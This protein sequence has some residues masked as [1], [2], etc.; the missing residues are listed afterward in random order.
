MRNRKSTFWISRRPSFEF[1]PFPTTFTSQYEVEK[2]NKHDDKHHQ[3]AQDHSHVIQPHSIQVKLCIWIKDWVEMQELGSWKH[4]KEGCITDLDRFT[5]LVPIVLYFWIYK[6][7]EEI[8]WVT[9]MNLKINALVL[10]LEESIRK[11]IYYTIQRSLTHVLTDQSLKW[12]ASP[13]IQSLLKG[14]VK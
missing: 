7:G 2:E 14:K 1:P 10:S 11:Q 6:V 4:R 13:R 8:V 9:W 12:W 5:F 3:H